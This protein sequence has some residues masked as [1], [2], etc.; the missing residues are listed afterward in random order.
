LEQSKLYK[1]VLM[2][3]RS[4]LRLHDNPAL[5]LAL[6]QSEEV[7]PVFILDD[8]LL[9]HD[10]LAGSARVL[11]M[12]DCLRD[13]HQ[14]L[15]HCGSYLVLR[16]ASPL[17]AIE[18]LLG[19]TQAEAVF[20][21]QDVD[22][23]YG[24]ERDQALRHHLTTV[25]HPPLA[26]IAVQQYAVWQPNTI[27]SL[28]D[29]ADYPRWHA[30][31]KQKWREWNAQK[32]APTPTKL[33][34]P[35]GIATAIHTLPSEPKAAL[36]LLGVADLEQVGQVGGESVALTLF[37]NFLARKL[38]RYYFSVSYPAAVD[39][40]E[41]SSLLSPHLK[42]GSISGRWCIQQCARLLKQAKVEADENAQTFEAA[43][44]SNSGNFLTSAERTSLER[45]ITRLR[46]RE[47][48]YQSL[49]RYPQAEFEE[50]AAVF[51][52][53]RRPAVG[54]EWEAFVSGMTGYPMVDA[55]VRC[56]R[57]TGTLA[58]RIRATLASFVCYG[59]FME[60]QAGKDFFHQYLID[61]NP[62][63]WW[64]WQIQAGTIDYT[65]FFQIF[66][67]TVQAR[68]FDPR[69]RFIKKWVPELAKV[70][71]DVLSEPWRLSLPEQYE[72][73]CVIGRDYPARIIDWRKARQQAVRQLD[74]LRLSLLKQ[75]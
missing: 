28:Q 75:E 22:R 36:A 43:G 27:G 63:N 47:Q 23:S 58:F 2:W 31:W 41:A 52:K 34:T 39:E 6:A 18:Q 44:N 55:G 46:W 61:S 69:G 29:Q 57:R 10:P 21:N 35:S 1:R 74:P 66:N 13:L 7:V 3:F 64:Q 67:P 32:L 38:P 11:F 70:P 72:L 71:L 60:P 59:L 25:R 24:L 53:V 65:R 33:T 42:F 20:Y 50:V 9:R 45:F 14:N 17:T 4:D 51:R 30:E 68:K 19:E 40:N 48:M 56:L 5:S 15:Q 73:G 26:F 8:A 54:P 16:Y 37:A 49:Y 62:V 12:L